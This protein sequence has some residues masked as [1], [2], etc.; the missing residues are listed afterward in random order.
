M[1]DLSK[2][3]DNLIEDIDKVEGGREDTKRLSE[4]L[5]YNDL[6]RKLLKVVAENAPAGCSGEEFG[7]GLCFALAGAIEEAESDFDASHVNTINFLKDAIEVLESSYD[8]S[9]EIDEDVKELDKTEEESE[10]DKDD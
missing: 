5:A 10:E 6:A 9:L 7:K 3:L 4:E 8:N 1:F 2:E